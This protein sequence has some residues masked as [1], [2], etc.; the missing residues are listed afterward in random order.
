MMVFGFE[1]IEWALGYRLRGFL[2]EAL[3]EHRSPLSKKEDALALPGYFPP[4]VHFL[5]LKHAACLNLL[6]SGVGDV[7]PISFPVQL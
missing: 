1:E 6:L 3:R 2:V 4:P 7:I 5:L